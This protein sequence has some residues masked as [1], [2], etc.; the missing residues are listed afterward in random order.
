VTEGELRAIVQAAIDPLPLPLDGHDAWAAVCT[1][2]R[3][4]G[5]PAPSGLGFRRTATDKVMVSFRGHNGIEVT[6]A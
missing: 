3:T 6:H 2:L 1:G 4:A 5:Y